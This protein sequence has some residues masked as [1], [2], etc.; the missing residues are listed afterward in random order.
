MQEISAHECEL[1]M[2]FLL[3]QDVIFHRIPTHLDIE[4]QITSPRYVEKLVS[5][6]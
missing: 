3:C 5:S 4:T 1:S 2:R 6:K